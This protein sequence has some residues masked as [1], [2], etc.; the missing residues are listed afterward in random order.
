MTIHPRA[1]LAKSTFAAAALTGLLAQAALA[2]DSTGPRPGLWE[3]SSQ[4]STSSGELEAAMRQAQA[5]LASMPAEQRKMMEQMMARQ[6]MAMD[7]ARQTVQVCMTAEDVARDQPPLAR[8]GCA[9]T[10][11]RSGNTW[12]IQ[13]QCKGGNGVPPSSGHGTMTLQSASA[14]SGDFTLRTSLQGKSEQLRMRTQGRWLSADCGSVK[15]VR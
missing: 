5:T 6:G 11:T 4:M 9:Q 2:G 13:F 3:H 15:P 8:E 7:L 12:T 10:A 14:Y 1:V